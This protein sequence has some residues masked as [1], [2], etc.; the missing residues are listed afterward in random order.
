[1]IFATLEDMTG[2]IDAVV[3]PTTYAKTRTFWYKDAALLVSGSV[4]KRDD[5]LSVLVDNIYPLDV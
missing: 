4:D 3:F 5:K 1:M 2:S